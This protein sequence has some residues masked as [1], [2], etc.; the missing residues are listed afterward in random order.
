MWTTKDEYKNERRKGK[1]F[2]RVKFAKINYQLR[3]M[4]NVYI[5]GTYVNIGNG[6]NEQQGIKNTHWERG[7][8][9]FCFCFFGSMK[10]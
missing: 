4:C 10:R 6:A 2:F 5:G 8:Q 1:H 7:M 9:H 3:Q